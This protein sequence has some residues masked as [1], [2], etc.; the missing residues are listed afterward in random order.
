MLKSGFDSTF[1]SFFY[2]LKELKV[3]KSD[4]YFLNRRNKYKLRFSVYGVECI[5]DQVFMIK[6]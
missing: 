2:F 4:S 5:C 3:C 1:T 6:Y